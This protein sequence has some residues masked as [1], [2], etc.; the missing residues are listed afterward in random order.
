MAFIK[1]TIRYFKALG[2]S[3]ALGDIGKIERGNNK[4]S[5]KV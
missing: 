5:N 2:Y 3:D 1:C 4:S